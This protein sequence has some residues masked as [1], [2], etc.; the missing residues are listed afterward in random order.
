MLYRRYVHVVQLF[1]C[2]IYEGIPHLYAKVIQKCL[3]LKGRLL[4]VNK[5]EN[6]LVCMV[7][8]PRD[9]RGLR[10]VILT[11]GQGVIQGGGR[12]QGVQDLSRAGCSPPVPTREILL[13][14]CQRTEGKGCQFQ[15]T[16][17]VLVIQLQSLCAQM[18]PT[19]PCA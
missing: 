14:L 6:Q 1:G 9:T 5:S 2:H 17:Q 11:S 13:Q 4:I 15:E 3:P 19:V 7:N 16:F 12:M 8:D 10:Q 18:D